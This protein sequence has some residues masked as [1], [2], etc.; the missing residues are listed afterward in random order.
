M[1]LATWWDQFQFNGVSVSAMAGGFPCGANKGR[2]NAFPHYKEKRVRTTDLIPL[3]VFPSSSSPPVLDVFQ[4][5]AAPLIG[6]AMK[7]SRELDF[8]KVRRACS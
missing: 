1:L 3:P 2:L 5:I 6:Y 4:V 7:W 8:L